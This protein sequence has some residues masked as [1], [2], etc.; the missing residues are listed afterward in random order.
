MI[1]VTCRW[2]TPVLLASLLQR[3][4]FPDFGKPRTEILGLMLRSSGMVSPWTYLEG[5]LR[6]CYCCSRLLGK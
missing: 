3:V 5:S 6:N 4:D 1:L 2:I